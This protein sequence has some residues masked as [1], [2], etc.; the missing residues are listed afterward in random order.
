MAQL[1][2]MYR[3]DGVRSARDPRGFYDRNVR[4]VID[5]HGE[6]YGWLKRE[7]MSSLEASNEPWQF[8][9]SLGDGRTVQMPGRFRRLPDARIYVQGII[10]TDTIR[11]GGGNAEGS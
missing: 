1:V 10:D 9:W 8:Y 3:V 4:F 7:G 5:E 2:L 6:S 11:K